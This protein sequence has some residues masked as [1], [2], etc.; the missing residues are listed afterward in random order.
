MNNCSGTDQLTCISLFQRA[1]CESGFTSQTKILK[2]VEGTAHYRA[3][4]PMACCELVK[5]NLTIIIIQRITHA[6]SNAQHSNA[7]AFANKPGVFHS[8]LCSSICLRVYMWSLQGFAF[9]KHACSYLVC[10][11][12]ALV[13]LS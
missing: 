5:V 9:L 3:L 2:S 10:C 11:S 6:H 13:S 1:H 8:L 4:F 12:S 7:F